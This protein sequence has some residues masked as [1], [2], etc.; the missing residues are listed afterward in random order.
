[1]TFK[2]WSR[3]AEIFHL[4]FSILI[5]DT[6]AVRNG[7]AGVCLQHSVDDEEHVNIPTGLHSTNYKALEEAATILEISG[8]T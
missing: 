2:G 5:R 8:R 4:Q 1:M 7:G 6:D 3:T